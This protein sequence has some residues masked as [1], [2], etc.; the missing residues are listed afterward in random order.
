MNALSDHNLGCGL[1]NRIKTLWEKGENAGK[2][3]RLKLLISFFDI[4]SITHFCMT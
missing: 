3:L 4:L 1:S 2:E